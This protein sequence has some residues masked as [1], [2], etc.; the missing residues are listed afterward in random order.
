MRHRTATV[1]L[2]VSTA[3]AACRPDGPDPTELMDADRAFAAAVA[4][5][6][7]DAW[8]AWFATDGA[9][10]QDGVGEVRGAAAIRDAV[11]YLDR[12][13]FALSWEPVRAEI[14]ASGDLGWTT[15]E[16]T[17][18]PAPGAPPGRGRY[19]SIWRR[20]PDGSWKVVM[21]LGVTLETDTA[22]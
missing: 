5:G 15:G 8:T 4:G 12:P 11:A 6:G 2:V 1:L 20:Q 13:G 16:W 19:V 17:L 18:R 7:A 22:G 21:D 3:T 14:A 9:M 10:L